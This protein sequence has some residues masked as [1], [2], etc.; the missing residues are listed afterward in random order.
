MDAWIGRIT[1]PLA[2]VILVVEVVILAAGVF[3]R[4]VLHNAIVWTDEVATILLLWL[5]MLGAVV[6]V[7]PATSTSGCPSVVRRASRRDVR[8]D[9]GRRSH[10]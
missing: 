10:R 9:S 6:G 8:R 2:A 4:Y 7:S 1:E 3:S 5:A